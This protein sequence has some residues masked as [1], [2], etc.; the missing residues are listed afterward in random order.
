ML[1]TLSIE[2][3]IVQRN[4]AKYKEQAEE[5]IKKSSCTF[6]ESD[7]LN[8]IKNSNGNVY[9]ENLSSTLLPSNM[10]YDVFMSHSHADVLLAEQLKLAVEHQTGRKVFIDHEVWGNIAILQGMLAGNS[11]LDSRA[12]MNTTSSLVLLLSSA[13]MEMIAKC[14]V[15]LFLSTDN[16]TSENG[17]TNSPWLHA[18]LRYSRII[19]NLQNKGVVFDTGLSMSAE[20]AGL[21]VSYKLPTKHLTELSDWNSLIKECR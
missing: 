2:G 13:I 15:F 18:E 12:H 14:S 11:A 17:R 1:K 8:L 19:A 6:Q 5:Y 16:T 4:V 7:A 10:N 3:S 20:S 9:A 21:S